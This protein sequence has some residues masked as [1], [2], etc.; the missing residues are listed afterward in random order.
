VR[1]VLTGALVRAAAAVAR[2]RESVARDDQPYVEHIPATFRALVQNRVPA[3]N[4]P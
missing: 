2:P 3:P 4:G 1:L